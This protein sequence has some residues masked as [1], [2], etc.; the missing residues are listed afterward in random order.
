MKRSHRS[1][2]RVARL[3]LPVLA[4]PAVAAAAPDLARCAAI[5]AA[6]ERLACYDALSCGAIAAADERLACFDGLAKSRAARPHGVVAA[7]P[8]GAGT[9]GAPA[10]LPGDAGSFGRVQRPTPPPRAVE[11]VQQITAVVTRV[12]TDMQGVVHVSLDNGQVWTLVN[13]DRAFPSS[14]ETVTIRRAALGSFLMTTASHRTVR[15]ARTQ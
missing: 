2:S 12:E 3:A 8:A 14:G 7:P 6:D 5:G 1:W 10:A 9:A 15:V 11:G 4:L 13:Y